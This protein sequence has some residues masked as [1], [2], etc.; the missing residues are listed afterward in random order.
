MNKFL[1]IARA[2]ACPTRFDLLRLLGEDGMSVTNVASAMGLA[3]STVSHHLSALVRAG[4]AVRAVRGREAIYR[5]SPNRWQLVRTT[6]PA[7][8]RPTTVARSMAGAPS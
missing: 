6:S 8:P 7:M 5:W 3:P 1:V 2:V 4:L